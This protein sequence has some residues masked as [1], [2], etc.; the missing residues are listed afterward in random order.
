MQLVNS[1]RS[2]IENAIELQINLLEEL[3][4]QPSD[5]NN[6]PIDTLIWFRD[7]SESKWESTYFAKFQD[8]KVKTFQSGRTSKTENSI[9]IRQFAKLRDEDIGKY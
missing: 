3:K 6:V 4:A 1:I 7:R 2:R 5:W 8:N 9:S